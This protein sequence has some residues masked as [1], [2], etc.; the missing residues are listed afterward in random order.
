MRNK[1]KSKKR[2][3]GKETEG[4]RRWKIIIQLIIKHVK[5]QKRELSGAR[6]ITI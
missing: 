4:K 2:K 1:K 5:R 6:R 3:G